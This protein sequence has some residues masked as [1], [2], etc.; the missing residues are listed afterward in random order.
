MNVKF[1]GDK[2]I[3]SKQ[4]FMELIGGKI[5]VDIRQDN[6]P[7]SIEESVTQYLLSKGLR[8]GIKGFDYARTA[9]IHLLN[10]K[11]E[12]PMTGS[13][14]LYTY[15]AKQLNSTEL[16]VERAIRHSLEKAYKIN[17]PTNSEFLFSAADDLKF[18]IHKEGQA[19]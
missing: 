17:K 19:W 13:N 8:R 1:D 14:G 5:P 15:V 6:K 3:L 9:I 10:I 12:K 11:E 7:E 18:E 16:R 4:D 2:V